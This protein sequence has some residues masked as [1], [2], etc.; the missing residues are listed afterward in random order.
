VRWARE[1]T[2]CDDI[3]GEV[4]MGFFIALVAVAVAHVVIVGTHVFFS[5]VLLRAI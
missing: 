3:A 4:T 5:C 1:V 2:A